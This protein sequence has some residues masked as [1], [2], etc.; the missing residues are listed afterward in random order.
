MKRTRVL[1]A[2]AV[3]VG[4]FCLGS[5]VAAVVP[6]AEA[7]E[8]SA[9]QLQAQQVA[10]EVTALDQRLEASVA[11]YAEAAQDLAYLQRQIAD[12][13]KDLALARTQLRLAEQELGLRAEALYKQG[14][15][16]FLDF[17]LDSSSFEELLTQVDC[18]RRV[19]RR[20]ADIVE[21]V[22]RHGERVAAQRE[23]LE[24]DLARA[25]ALAEKRARQRAAI[26]ADLR[27]RE[28][29]LNGVRTEV[30][31]LQASMGQAADGGAARQGDNGA[32]GSSA[33]LQGKGA[34]WPL[35]QEVARKNDISAVG[36][37]RLMMAESGGVAGASNGVNHGL[38][39]YAYSTWKGSWNP[40]RT[41]GIFDGAAQIRATGLAIRQGHG[42]SWWAST[43][44]WAFSGD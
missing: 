19:G 9:K 3:F 43:Y 31:R 4:L 7:T 28:A 1:P 40:W 35:I 32:A 27:A 25:K 24:A 2:V 44:S 10:A 8:L 12:N 33:D 21:A 37:Y 16:S 34:W 5:L 20:D 15:V 36:L 41:S 18:F 38:F 42:P 11:R 22:E 39:Q 23:Q 26:D 30:S 14:E 29:L 13:Q 17:V 6:P